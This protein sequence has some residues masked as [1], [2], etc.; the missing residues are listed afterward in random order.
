MRSTAGA[1]MPARA[2]LISRRREVE[3]LLWWDCVIP[4]LPENGQFENDARAYPVEVETARAT[5]S[6]AL[7]D[8]SGPNLP[9][10]LWALVGRVDR[11]SEAEAGG[12]G[13]QLLT[14]VASSNNDP[15]PQPLPTRGRG[16]H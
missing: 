1:T 5:R 10:P 13:S 12:V 2:A 9:S 6:V 16:A 14:R 7:H 3:T 11:R 8:G 4:C 15:H